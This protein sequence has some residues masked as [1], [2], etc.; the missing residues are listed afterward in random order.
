MGDRIANCLTGLPAVKAKLTS[1]LESGMAALRS[2]AVRPRIKPWLDSFCNTSHNITEA[3]FAESSANDPW[4]Q[5]TI[6]NLDSMVHG[7]KP[8]LTAANCDR[9]GK[10]QPLSPSHHIWF[11]PNSLFS[12]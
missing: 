8:Q 6:V 1:V 5:Q 7:F 3:Q 12:S 2:S 9:L 4:V 11:Y 10:V